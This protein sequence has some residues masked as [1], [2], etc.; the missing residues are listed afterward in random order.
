M[1]ISTWIVRFIITRS[2]YV[3]DPQSLLFSVSL[4]D[5]ISNSETTSSNET[6]ADTGTSQEQCFHEQEAQ[7]KTQEKAEEKAEC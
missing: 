6:L 4:M 7:E 3:H 1:L 2:V 5:R